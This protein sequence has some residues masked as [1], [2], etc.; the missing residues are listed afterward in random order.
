MNSIFCH[1]GKNNN[2]NN[3]INN[4]KKKTAKTNW[5]LNY[6]RFDNDCT[7]VLAPTTWLPVIGYMFQFPAHFPRLPALAKVCSPALGSRF[8]FSRGQ[9]GPKAD[10]VHLNK[11]SLSHLQQ[12]NPPQYYPRRSS[13]LVFLPVPSPWREWDIQQL[14]SWH[15]QILSPK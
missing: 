15:E 2:N 3:N 5:F 4:N 13:E 14:F 10:Y 7:A 8:M 1:S 9:R 11:I 6:I 12:V